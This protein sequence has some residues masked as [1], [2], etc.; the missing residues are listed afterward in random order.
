MLNSW[1]TGRLCCRHLLDHSKDGLKLS[2]KRQKQRQTRAN[3]ISELETA[4]SPSGKSIKPF[5]VGCD[6]WFRGISLSKVYRSRGTF[7][8]NILLFGSTTALSVV[9]V[10]A[11]R[12]GSAAHTCKKKTPLQTKRNTHPCRFGSGPPNGSIQ[13]QICNHECTR[14]CKSP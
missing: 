4:G 9:S 14:T 10:N 1:K 7:H 2:K 13:G 12:L 6:S 5:I 3:A 8:H 11:S